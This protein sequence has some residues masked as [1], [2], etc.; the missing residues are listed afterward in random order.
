M[1]IYFNTI[2]KEAPGRLLP[3]FFKPAHRQGARLPENIKL[4]DKN[5]SARNE[6]SYSMF[7]N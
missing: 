6:N 1:F 5:F 2:E 4:V 3:S 7:T